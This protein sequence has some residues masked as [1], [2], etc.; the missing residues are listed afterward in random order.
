MG[1]DWDIGKGRPDTAAPLAA[2]CVAFGV[3]MLLQCVSA[4]ML[5]FPEISKRFFK[6]FQDIIY[7]HPEK[8]ERLPAEQ[9]NAVKR[10]VQACLRHPTVE[11]QSVGLEV[12][13]TV[14]THRFKKN[15]KSV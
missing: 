4:E 13:C 7:S 5:Q 3:N 15:Q 10:C 9:L 11:I 2:D 8:V 12:T 6:L 1:D 14:G